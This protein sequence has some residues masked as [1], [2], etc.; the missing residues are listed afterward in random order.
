MAI[1]IDEEIPGICENDTCE[2]YQS[3]ELYNVSD[4]KKSDDGDFVL[5]AYCDRPI[6][7]ED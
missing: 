5:C 3:F 1:Q 6:F 4:V 7:L 2:A